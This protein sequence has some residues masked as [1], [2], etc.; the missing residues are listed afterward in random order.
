MRKVRTIHYKTFDD[1]VVV[2]SNQDYVLS[3]DY[4]WV[5][6]GLGRRFG[7]ALVYSLAYVFAFLYAKL[8]LHCRVENRAALKAVKGEGYFVYCNHT[9]PVGDVFVPAYLNRDRRIYTI[10]SQ[11]NYGLPVIGRILPYL[12]ALPIPSNMAD[13]KKFTSAI[14]ERV[15]TRH[16]II[17]FP[18]GHVWPWY[19]GI[20]PFGPNAFHYPVAEEKPVFSMTLTYHRRRLSSKP[21][22][23]VYIDGPFY[24]EAALPRREQKERLCEEVRQAMERRSLESDYSY[25]E[26]IQDENES[27]RSFE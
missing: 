10:V 21:R 11:A 22:T 6:N 26:Y 19:T 15:N 3:E 7:S 27:E 12:G 4:K 18:E 23:R 9:Q 8:A 24:P 2:N 13:M 14:S 16:C 20:R 25:I 1:D 5:D 17:V